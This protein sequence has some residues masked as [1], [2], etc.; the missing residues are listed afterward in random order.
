M[1]STRELIDALDEEPAESG[2]VVALVVA[3]KKFTKFVFTGHSNKLEKLNGLVRE[4]GEPVG[5]IV[6]T[7]KG[8]EGNVRVCALP[9]YEGDR[10]IQNFLATLA[11]NCGVVLEAAG[12][13][14]VWQQGLPRRSH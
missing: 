2:A 14:Q 12:K 1:R 6:I 8:K 13:G 5:I 11:V 3:F 10:E 7:A 9:E 4:G